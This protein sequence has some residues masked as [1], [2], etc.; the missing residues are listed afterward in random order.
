MHRILKRVIG[1]LRWLFSSEQ[2]PEAAPRR[3]RSRGVIRWVLAPDDTAA[4]RGGSQRE[5]RPGFVSTVLAP[6]TLPRI[7]A[8][9]AAAPPRTGFLRWLTASEQCPTGSGPA[10][11]RRGRFLSDLLSPTELPRTPAPD[12]QRAHGFLRRLFSREEL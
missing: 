1:A 11:P 6:E 3:Q 2:L 7:D 4:A 5:C 12:P 9:A 8:P 10:R